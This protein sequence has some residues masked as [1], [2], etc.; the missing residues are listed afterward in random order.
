MSRDTRRQSKRQRH[1]PP[2]PRYNSTSAALSSSAGSISGSSQSTSNRTPTPT[3]GRYAQ[4]QTY[5]QDD[6]SQITH[7]S[8]RSHLSDR[9]RGSSYDGLNTSPAVRPN[10]SFMPIVNT[11]GAVLA[12]GYAPP[13]I[14]PEDVNATLAREA[15][16]RRSHQM[17]ITRFVA[18][19]ILPHLKFLDNINYSVAYS[20]LPQSLCQIVITRCFKHPPEREW[21]VNDGSKMVQ[22]AIHRLRNDRMQAVKKTFLGMSHLKSPPGLVLYHTILTTTSACSIGILQS[23]CRKPKI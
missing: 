11:G 18:E 15:D 20:D 17:Q 9:S 16:I 14:V 7:V 19:N 1:L 12:P 21:W 4:A 3:R 2:T 5:L 10:P 23:G 6:H 13:N 8:Q 22:H